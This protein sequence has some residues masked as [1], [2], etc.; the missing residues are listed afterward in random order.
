MPVAGTYDTVTKSPMGDQKGTL[1]VTPGAD[2]TTFTGS[3]VGGLGSLEVK[4]GKIVD[5]KTITWTMDMTAPLPLSLEAKAT[6][7]G[8][9]L[10]GTVNAGAFG[11]LPISGTRTG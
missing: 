1:T 9:T 8:N 10:T 6:I 4:N 5:D 11:D 2:G 7:D 3:L